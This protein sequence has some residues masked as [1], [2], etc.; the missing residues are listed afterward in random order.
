M[1]LITAT[2]MIKGVLEAVNLLIPPTKA[3][4]TITIR[5]GEL[6][7]TLYLPDKF[8]EVTFDPGDDIGPFVT[9]LE[10]E[11]TEAGYLPLK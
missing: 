10:K 11:L 6:L 5:D 2:K 7:L 4:H 1:K 9:L 3:P 8:I